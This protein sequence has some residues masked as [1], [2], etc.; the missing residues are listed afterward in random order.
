MYCELQRSGSSLL[1]GLW[2]WQLLLAGVDVKASGHWSSICSEVNNEAA[3]V[4]IEL[5]AEGGVEIERQVFLARREGFAFLADAVKCPRKTSGEYQ[6]R[7][8]LAAKMRWQ[9][10]LETHEGNL[11]AGRRRAARV[12]PLSL[13]E[14]RAERGG[15]LHESNRHLQLTIPFH[16]QRLH[17]ALFIDLDGRRQRRPITWRRLTVGESLKT[18]PS[19]VAVGYRIQ[20]G[21][22]Q[23]L[24]YRSLAPRDNRTVLGQNFSSEFFVARFPPSG[25]AE[26]LLEIE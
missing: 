6:M 14:W 13:P 19:D 21:R 24:I 18:V 11:F 4:E 17:A 1:A 8:P 15:R 23:W 25:I 2:E 7:V 10:T 9:E 5:Q 26:K 3:Y 12:I 22:S 20:V 16:G